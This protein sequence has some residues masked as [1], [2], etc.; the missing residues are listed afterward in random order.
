MALAGV[1]ELVHELVGWPYHHDLDLTGFVDGTENPTVVEATQ[2]AIIED[3]RRGAGSS[4]LLL[5]QWEHDA[6]A[7]EGLPVAAQEAIVGRRKADSAELDPAPPDS[8]VGRTDQ[9]VF[10]KIFRR[11]IAYGTLG[12]HGTIFVG[13]CREQSV[14]EAMLKSMVG[15]PGH[16]PD[17]L[18]TVT[19]PL[20]SAYYVIP[21]A[22]V[23]AA[24][25]TD[26]RRRGLARLSGPSR[27]PWP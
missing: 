11:N 18:M 24:L 8:H 4:I 13:F 20:T 27:S 14:L 22:D 15:E 10:G 3:G 23:L 21:S 12:R 6:I 16:P 17:R 7:W 2:V 5:Q 19:K 1:A 25:G 9:E 26:R